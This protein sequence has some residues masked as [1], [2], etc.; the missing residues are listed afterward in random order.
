[1]CVW[2]G[3]VA[4]GYGTRGAR[5]RASKGAGCTRMWQGHVDKVT[6]TKCDNADS[7]SGTSPVS[8]FCWTAKRLRTPHMEA[9]KRLA[10]LRAPDS[11][12]RR[13]G[14]DAGGAGG[15]GRGGGGRVTGRSVTPTRA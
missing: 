7:D 14:A 9:R 8:E 10:V 2:G 5:A 13:K 6:Y 3:G 15:V 1:V 11:G 4:E 12:E